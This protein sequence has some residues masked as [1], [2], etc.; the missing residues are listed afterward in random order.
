MRQETL[1]LTHAVT[2]LKERIS[3]PH[4]ARPPKFSYKYQHHVLATIQQILEES[5]FNFT[6]AWLPAVLV[7][8][9]WTCAAAVELTKWLEIMQKHLKTLPED[10]IDESGRAMFKEI[11]PRLA[12]LRHSA[13]HRLHLAPD[14]VLEEV[15]AAL[16]LAKTLRDGSCTSKLQALHTRLEETIGQTKHDT[17]AM[18]QE[19]NHAY[20]AIQRQRKALDRQEQQLRAYAAEQ[21]SRISEAA[22]LSLLDCAYVLRDVRGPERGSEQSIQCNKHSVVS[23]CSVCVDEDDIESDEDQLKADLG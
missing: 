5:C 7:E 20:L 17:E 2:N 19:V 9:A 16:M 15:H 11:R 18:Q 22:D 10:C 21:I 12:H 3:F 1:R 8:S 13:V 6:Q 23:D 4:N 14:K